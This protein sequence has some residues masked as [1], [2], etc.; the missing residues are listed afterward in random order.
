MHLGSAVSVPPGDREAARRQATHWS[1]GDAGTGVDHRVARGEQVHPQAR[2]D[3]LEGL[4]GGCG[5]R[6]D[7]CGA[8]VPFRGRQPELA[9]RPGFRRQGDERLVQQFPELDLLAGREAVP[10]GERDPAWLGPEHPMV[11][12]GRRGQPEEGHVTAFVQQA[13]LGSVQ[14]CNRVDSRQPAA[15]SVKRRRAAGYRSRPM[16][17]CSP[18]RSTRWS[19]AS[20]V[21]ASRAASLHSL[22]RRWAC[23]RSARPAGLSVTP[24]ESRRSS[25]ARR[26]RSSW[27]ICL[28]STGW[29]TYR[30]LA[31]RV[32]LS[33]SATATK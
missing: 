2:G 29:E 17:V 19:C 7:G 31:A 20:A 32:K 8:A 23:G 12:P 33:S 21:T 26:F 1:A 10:A 3:R 16:L 13:A 22:S 18:T 9:H 27:R 24:R 5:L 6:S 4:V 30:R 11:D 14:A 25:V 15:S 28:L